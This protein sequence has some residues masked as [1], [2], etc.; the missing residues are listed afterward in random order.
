MCALH[1][2]TQ[3][4][5]HTLTQSCNILFGRIVLLPVA[6]HLTCNY[7]LLSR[8]HFKSDNQQQRQQNGLDSL[9]RGGQGWEDKCYLNTF[10]CG[11]PLSM[12]RLW[13][14]LRLWLWLWLW[15]YMGYRYWGLYICMSLCCVWVFIIMGLEIAEES[16][17]ERARVYSVRWQQQKVKMSRK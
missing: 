8:A 15:L 6:D 12:T 9:H 3:T 14:R 13:L 11:S 7:R 1:L 2:H 5:T 17:R 16:V 10:K 4:L